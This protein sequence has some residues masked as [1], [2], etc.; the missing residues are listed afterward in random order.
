MKMR[1]RMWSVKQK[2]MY[3]PEELAADQLTLLST[4]EFINVASIT[5]CSVIYDVD[6]YIP[7]HSTL[8]SVSNGE[9]FE[10]DIVESKDP[11]FGSHGFIGIVKW[12]DDC[13]GFAIKWVDVD[14][15]D[16]DTDEDHQMLSDVD[17]NSLVKIG[18]E[19]EGRYNEGE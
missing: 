3:Y 10:S 4:G 14:S 16:P 5:S 15:D 2:R 19:Y 1:V 6:H 7:L 9:L 13:A 17:L 18:N 8:L 11:I 12:L